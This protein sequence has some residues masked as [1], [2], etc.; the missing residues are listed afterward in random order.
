M[1]LKN[2][3]ELANYICRKAKLESLKYTYEKRA[4]M[5]VEALK[6][7]LKDFVIRT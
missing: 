1:L 2:D 4:E 6:G 7:L 3:K 5:L